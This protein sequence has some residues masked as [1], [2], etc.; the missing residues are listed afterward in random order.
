MVM[1]FK[2]LAIQFPE[3]ERIELIHQMIFPLIMD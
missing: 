2:G 1:E 3:N